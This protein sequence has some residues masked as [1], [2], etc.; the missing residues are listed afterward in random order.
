MK[1]R[2]SETAGNMGREA[3]VKCEAIRRF[4]V[5]VGKKNREAEG[6]MY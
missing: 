5:G 4:A 1:T 2:R 6:M 3:S